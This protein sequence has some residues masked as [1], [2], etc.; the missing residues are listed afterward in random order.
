MDE[1]VRIVAEMN[2]W[3]F[4]LLKAALDDMGDDEI[5]W[6][7]LP[8]GNSIN[9]IVR[10]LRIEARWHLDSLMRGDAMPLDVSPALQKE[11]DAVPFD[12]QRNRDEL[13]TLLSGFLDLLRAATPEALEQRTGAAYGAMGDRPELAH[14]LGYH[15]A[16]HVAIHCGQI[17]TIRN[18]Y[19][20]SRGEPARFFP[21]SPT[22][23]RPDGSR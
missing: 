14:F 21:D 5:D 20:K 19:R 11:I 16:V 9:T 22:Y 12:F 8:Y 13:E 18:L 17:R 23:P 4:S 3:V 15:Q 2:R 6:R 7:P 10:H 1:A